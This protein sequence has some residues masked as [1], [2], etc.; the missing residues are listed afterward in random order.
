MYWKHHAQDGDKSQEAAV[1]Q[2]LVA[3]ERLEGTLQTLHVSVG[4]DCSWVSLTVY[5]A[6]FFPY[7]FIH[8]L[9]SLSIVCKREENQNQLLGHLIFPI[10]SK[11][12]RHSSEAFIDPQEFRLD[13]GDFFAINIPRTGRHSVPAV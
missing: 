13:G 5:S 3:E 4:P 11:Q 1:A 12:W 7:H 2:L 9:N 8:F 10:P 6:C